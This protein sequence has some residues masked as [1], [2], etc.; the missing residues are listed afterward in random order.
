MI[1]VSRF[2][3]TGDRI[4][5]ILLHSRWHARRWVE[6]AYPE[7]GLAEWKCMHAPVNRRRGTKQNHQRR[8]RRRDIK[9]SGKGWTQMTSVCNGEQCRSRWTR[10]DI[11]FVLHVILLSNIRGPG[12]WR[13]R[14]DQLI[15]IE[16]YF[17]FTESYYN[18]L[19]SS[20]NYY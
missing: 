13:L 4:C 20:T 3:I 17:N 16:I 10:E 9:I 6:G 2:V 15:L 19:L 7:N 8:M 12:P 18:L 5:T 1:A 14:V 11:N